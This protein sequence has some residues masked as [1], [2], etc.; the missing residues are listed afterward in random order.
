MKYFIFSFFLLTAFSCVGQ[1][2]NS[3]GYVT[4]QLSVLPNENFIFDGLCPVGLL[5]GDEEFDGNGPRIKCEVRLRI[6]KDSTALEADIYFWAQ[7]TKSDW[8]TTEGR[9]NK[10]IY[11]APHG[12]RITKILSDNY[13][14]TELICQKNKESIFI[15]GEDSTVSIT[16]FM[17]GTLM[18]DAVMI[19]HFIRLRP[20]IDNRM[21]SNLVR[22]YTTTNNNTAIQVP[23]KK[24]TLVKFFHFV[25]DTGGKDIS[26]DDNCNDDTRIVNIEFFPIQLEVKQKQ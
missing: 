13:S 14:A 12:T 19:K 2:N 9:W 17:G 20:R 8:S 11:T 10:K 24:G 4:R 18:D 21:L 25:G 26:N 22:F 5:K 6:I 1:N 7:E 16:R 23:A 15:K 3:G